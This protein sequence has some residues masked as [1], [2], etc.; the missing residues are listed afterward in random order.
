MVPLTIA[1]SNHPRLLAEGLTDA[2]FRLRVWTRQ[3]KEEV[4]HSEGGESRDM[5]NPVP[6]RKTG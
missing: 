4:V 1:L 6:G 5:R 2:C 3:T